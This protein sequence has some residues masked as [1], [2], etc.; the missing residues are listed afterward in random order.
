M[1]SSKLFQ[2][3]GRWINY[4]MHYKIRTIFIIYKFAL[5]IFKNKKKW[6]II[7]F[8]QLHKYGGQKITIII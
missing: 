8:Y 4:Q 3:D 1:W 6:K 2:L 5:K 7:F